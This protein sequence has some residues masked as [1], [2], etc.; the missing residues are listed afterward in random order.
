MMLFANLLMAAVV[1]VEVP[2]EVSNAGFEG[3]KTGWNFCPNQSVVADNPHSGKACAF[4]DMVPVR[5]D[6]VYLTRKV[7]VDAGAEYG[8]ECWIRTEDVKPDPAIRQGSCGA[9]LIVEWC[10]SNGKWIATGQYVGNFYG[11]KEW[12]KVRAEQLKAP[13]DAAYAQIYLALRGGGRAWFDDFRF[14]KRVVPTEKTQPAD[15]ATLMTNTPEFG[16]KYRPGAR[17]F[18]VVISKSPS[19]PKD[20]SLVY[21]AG[22]FYGYQIE[23]PLAPGRWY[24][25]VI[26]KGQEEDTPWSFTVADATAGKD[27]L[28][29]QLLTPAKRILS[30]GDAVGVRLREMN[31]VPQAEF[32]GVK[33]SVS[34]LDGGEYRCRF[35]APAAGWPQGFTEG[36]V[37]VADAAG[38]HAEHSFWLLNAPKPENAVVVGTDGMFHERGKRI[39]PLGIYEVAPKY[40]D[41]VRAS[42]IDVVHTYRW[43]SDSN[44]VACGKYLDECHSH[45]LRAFIGFPR[46]NG[47]EGRG[48]K[49]ANFEQ[50]AR[51][52]GHLAGHPAMF[53]WYLFDEPEH[54]G[55]FVTPDVLTRHA[56]I[57][58]ALDPFHPVVMSTWERNMHEHRRTWDTHWSQ[59][60]GKPADVVSLIGTQRKYIGCSSPITTLLNCNDG[61]QT[62]AVRRKE[63][64]DPLH[65]KFQRDYDWFRACAY[66]AIAKETNGIWWW[67]YGRDCKEYVTAGQVPAA[68]ADLTRVNRE[69]IALRPLLAAEGPVTTGRAIDGKA[70]VEW[71]AKL[72]DGQ[73]FAIIVNTAEK[74]VAVDIDLPLIGRRHHKLG[75]F[76]V[77]MVK[78]Q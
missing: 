11:T 62:A 77:R 66:L 38:N 48:I 25:K 35:D 53:C 9:A 4:V 36:V 2:I 39:F 74:P 52:V 19:F 55:Q 49:Q 17:R 33:G 44:D 21:E 57:I 29:P 32:L 16:W 26:S 18:S 42:G 13:P 72:V 61:V 40:M 14:F 41:E 22:G 27:T 54:F 46:G 34:K 65:T 67:W 51:R 56:D 63:K 68:W 76:E 1:V 47:K 37:K 10:N 58:R 69:I 45:G 15:G 70:I 7:P 59:A 28:V 75:R 71:W 64:V 73:L 43:E 23:R 24:W 50:T 12:S 5:P 3:G 8:A 31:G 78:D 60:Y 20:A 30:S 6:S